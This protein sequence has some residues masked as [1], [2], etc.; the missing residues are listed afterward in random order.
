MFGN[1]LA[2]KIERLKIPMILVKMWCVPLAV[3][4]W[5]TRRQVKARN[6]FLDFKS[7]QKV[8]TARGLDNVTEEEMC[9]RKK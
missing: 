9:S 8:L 3:L 7:T 1:D 2:D 6:L 4:V 5:K